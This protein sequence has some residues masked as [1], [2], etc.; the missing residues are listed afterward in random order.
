MNRIAVA[1]TSAIL[2]LCALGMA[3]GQAKNGDKDSS[4]PAFKILNGSRANPR[5]TLA[6]LL[7]S[8]EKAVGGKEA[9]EK[10]RTAVVYEER[11]AQTKSGDPRSGTSTEY[12][13]FKL[14]NEAL[15]IPS[16]KDV[17]GY[18]C[19]TIWH[20]GPNEGIQKMSREMNVFAAQ[21]L[22]LFSLLHLRAAFPQMTL[23][24]A[25]KVENRDAYMVYAPLESLGLHRSLFFDAETRLLIGSVVVQ[26]AP[27]RTVISE[28]FYSDFRVVNGIKFPFKF[29][30]F[31]HNS[32]SSLEIRVS[33]IECNIPST[34]LVNSTTAERSGT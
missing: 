1:V 4:N 34:R 29:R 10:I 9:V 21:E 18:D 27:G 22:N 17:P 11:R 6:E 33:H 31:E 14:P 7:D 5:I 28:Q 12:F 3:A 15:T 23:A 13:N 2:L 32:Q 24:G 16:S 8:Y 30:A 20:D 26:Q 19:E 25:S